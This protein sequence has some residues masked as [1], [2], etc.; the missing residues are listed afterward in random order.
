MVLL[1]FHSTIL[2]ILTNFDLNFHPIFDLSVKTEPWKSEAFLQTP[3][4][5]LPGVESAFVIWDPVM[6]SSI[7]RSYPPEGQTGAFDVHSVYRAFW[8]CMHRSWAQKTSLIGYI[9][10]PGYHQF[11]IFVWEL[12]VYPRLRY[13]VWSIACILL[14]L[15]FSGIVPL[16]LSLPRP[17]QRNSFSVPVRGIGP[18]EDNYC[19]VLSK[20]GHG[21][22]PAFHIRLF[23]MVHNR[24]DN[25][26]RARPYCPF[27]SL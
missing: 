7:F 22:F 12:K 11:C 10:K 4:F 25:G 18:D 17:L 1:A 19:N 24:P 9:Q 6:L 15:A 3:I 16:L 20:T 26:Q 21:R 14:W 13:A 27:Q 5:P 23:L 2:D 8:Y